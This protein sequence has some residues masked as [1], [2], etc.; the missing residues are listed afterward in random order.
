MQRKYLA[1]T[2]RVDEREDPLNT[3]QRR[4]QFQKQPFDGKTDS[5]TIIDEAKSNS[6]KQKCQ[7][8]LSTCY[9]IQF[10]QWTHKEKL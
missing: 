7:L 9:S 4:F 1:K 2:D 10:M 5:M 6:T 8:Y 3:S